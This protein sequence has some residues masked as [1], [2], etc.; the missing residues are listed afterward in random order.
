MTKILIVGP[1]WV[2]DMMMAQTLFLLL[3]QHHENLQLDVLA[4]SW[5]LPL[6]SRMPEV[7]QAIVSP[8]AHGELALR[9]RY[10]L[11][12]SLRAKQYDQA[13]VLPNSLKSALIPFLAKIPKRTGWLGEKRYGLLNDIR[14]L[15]KDALPKMV[16]RFAALACKRFR[17]LPV[18]SDLPCGTCCGG[19]SAPG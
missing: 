19:H 7:N 6:L 13:I 11:A 9:K 2:G 4:P 3:H 5:S 8:F 18:R 1:S 14:H 17:T 10:Q 15:D 12:K 16:Q